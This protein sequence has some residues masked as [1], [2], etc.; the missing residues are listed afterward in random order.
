[1]T[2]LAQTLDLP[3]SSH[4]H[5]NR[6]ASGVFIRS[7]YDAESG[8]WASKDP[9]LFRGGDLNLFGYVANDPVN[10]IDPLGLYQIC[11][12]PLNMSGGEALQSKDPTISHQ[13]IQYEDGT[14][15]SYGTNGSPFGGA[16][17]KIDESGSAAV[18]SKNIKV[19]QKVENNMKSY[20]KKLYSRPYSLLNNNCQHF[21][22]DVV[23]NGS[24]L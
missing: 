14:T 18:C 12:R 13:Y 17:A 2:S 4:S 9:I 24:G 23:L 20:A 3:L 11:S 7:H 6:S 8:R 10:F 1:M 5:E 19:G 15:D 16:G 21:V 22:G